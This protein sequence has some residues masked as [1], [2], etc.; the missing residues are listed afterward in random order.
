M[1]SDV[2]M[3]GHLKGCPERLGVE[4]RSHH[5]ME[6]SWSLSGSLS[7][8][9]CKQQRWNGMGNNTKLDCLSMETTKQH[10]TTFEPSKLLPHHHFQSE[11]V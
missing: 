3:L 5:H 4:S 10:Q 8:A 11:M 2:L 1:D 9:E 6:W 7:R